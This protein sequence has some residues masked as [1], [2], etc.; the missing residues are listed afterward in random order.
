LRGDFYLSNEEVAVVDEEAERRAFGERGPANSPAKSVVFV[1]DALE[2]CR[3]AAIGGEL[4][5]V[6]AVVDWE[7]ATRCKVDLTVAQ[8]TMR[9]YKALSLGGIVHLAGK[10]ATRQGQKSTR[11]QVLE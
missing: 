2:Q 4:A 3:L 5:Q 7:K 6:E 11:I 9:P 1:I 10:P 8:A